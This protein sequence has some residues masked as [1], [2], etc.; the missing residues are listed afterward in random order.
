MRTQFTQYLKAYRLVHGLSTASAA[1]AAGI[2]P[3]AWRVYESGT[4]PGRD[5]LAHLAKYFDC[6]APKLA[7]MAETP[8]DADFFGKPLIATV[9]EIFAGLGQ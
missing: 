3:G 4:L 8:A 7:Q 9:A 2:S 5:G 1:T 6:D